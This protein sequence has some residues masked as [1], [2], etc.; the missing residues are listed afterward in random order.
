MQLTIQLSFH[1]IFDFTPNWFDW[2]TLILT[3]ASI[4]GAYWVAK[5]VYG[6]EKDDKK[7]E[8]KELENSENLL[9]INNLETIQKPIISQ[10]KSLK[11]YVD[12]QDFRLSFNPEIQVDFLQ[13]IN[14]KDIYKK[15]GFD[16]KKN[17]E[18]INNLMTSLYSLYDFRASLR[19]EVR[20]YIEK[21]NYHEQKFY[22]YRSLMYTK[23]FELCNTRAEKIVNE[24]GIKKWVFNQNDKFMSEYSALRNKTFDDKEII[25][26]NG[27]ISRDFMIERFIN[28]LVEISSKYI[29]EDYNAIEIN[30][31]SNDVRAAFIDMTHVTEKHFIA[32]RSHIKSL[33]NVNAQMKFFNKIK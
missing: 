25:E 31:L 26:N 28:P 24:N 1:R 5:T 27:L 33:E 12:I 19:N 8:D 22:N 21:Y 14:I 15:H 3:I 30:E 17:I 32:I 10:I 4:I 23:Y 13:F 7:L 9:F 16:N 2:L 29:P 18:I 11:E 6:K 20:T